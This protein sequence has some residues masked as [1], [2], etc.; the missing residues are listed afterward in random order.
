MPIPARA[1]RP[2][3]NR[4]GHIVRSAHTKQMVRFLP[5]TFIYFKTNHILA[6][7]MCGK[8]N[9]KTTDAAPVIAGQKFTLK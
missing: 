5:H 1:V 7:A 4:V 6:C 2:K 9:S 3:L 8:P